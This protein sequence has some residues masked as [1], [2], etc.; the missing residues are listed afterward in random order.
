MPGDRMTTTLPRARRSS[1]PPRPAC[2][3]EAGRAELSTQAAS[4]RANRRHSARPTKVL[5]GYV[6]ELGRHREIVGCGGAHG[7]R[8][9]IDRDRLTSGDRRLVAHLG[10]DEPAENARIVC[11]LYIEDERKRCR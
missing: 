10:A 6:D 11:D 1:A 3:G 4:C 9:V 8:L 5:A 2:R 7:S